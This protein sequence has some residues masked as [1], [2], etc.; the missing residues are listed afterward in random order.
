M[1]LLIN[2]LALV[3]FQT[4]VEVPFR[5]GD[6]ALILD[7][8]VNGRK[9][10]V[11]FD[12]GFG[13]AVDLSNT[14]N[15][16][17]PDGTARLR[18][19]V[20]ELDAQT[21]KIK[22][23]T[24]GSKS[25]DAAGMDVVLSRPEDYSFIYGQHCDGIMGFGVIKNNVTEI[26]FQKQK[27]VFY[28]NSFDIS[29]RTPDNKKT[30]LVKMLPLGTNAVE[31]PVLTPNGQTLTM[32]LDTGNSFYATSH[33]DSLERVGLWDSGKDPKF[34]TMAGVASGAVVSWNKKMANMT[35]FG[36]PVPAST[37]DVIDLP[38]SSAEADGTVGF[39]FLRNFNIIIDYN[40][41]RVWLENWTSKVEN[42]P[43]GDLGISALYSSNSRSV[44]IVSVSPDSPADVAGI[45]KG[46]E[47]L[48]IGTTDLS[49]LISYKKLR[50]MLLGPSGS[51]V[52]LATSRQGSLK[53][54]ELERKALVND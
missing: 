30:F 53:R 24:I 26:N 43:P 3:A 32:A 29:T 13:G 18:D 44:V 20:G 51:K 17:E 11:M 31:L 22:S 37:W 5:V 40:R 36:V 2:L 48:S 10:S 7:A 46:D 52:K 54:Y 21:V 23:L 47:L 39:E 6:Q 35:I 16:G 25:V 49:G 34:T 14:I 41:R 45:K 1:P 33:R 19:F 9:V 4:P 27:F 12:T 8:V 28:P 38:S 50:K 15:V 42:D